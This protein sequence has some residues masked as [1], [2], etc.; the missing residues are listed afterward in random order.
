MLRISMFVALFTAFPAMAGGGPTAELQLGYT[1]AHQRAQLAEAAV[2]AMEARLAK[3]EDFLRRQGMDDPEG[4]GSLSDVVAELARVRGRLEELDFLM[5]GVR[6]DL[7]QYMVDLER[8]QLFDESR[9][10]QLEGLLGVR[11]PAPPRVGGEQEPTEPTEPVGEPDAPTEPAVEV[12]TD[13]AGRLALARVRIDAGQQAAARAILEQALAEAPDDPLAPEIQY[14][15][16]ETWFNE[17]KFKQAARSYQMVTDE[18]AR[19]PW[20]PWSMYKIGECF[21]EMGRA[22]AAKTFYE[23]VVR[24]YPQSEAAKEAKVRLGQ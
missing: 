10:A 13:P 18:H 14:R 6:A 22:D 20:A 7:D 21:A 24:N 17:G 11:A 3:M 5:K 23:G 16:G 2:E 4:V 1:L 15:I 12:P 8:R 19:S 9:L